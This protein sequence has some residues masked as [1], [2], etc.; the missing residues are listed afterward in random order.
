MSN[1]RA[2]LV[3]LHGI[4]GNAAGF[5]PVV[6]ALEALGWPAV[7]WSQPG[8]DGTPL[9]EPYCLDAC[10]QALGAWL[11]TRGPGRIVL[12]GHSMGGMLAQA[13]SAQGGA[14]ASGVELAGLVLAHTSPAF[15]KPGGDFQQRFIASRTRPLDEGKTM[16]EIAATLVPAMMAPTASAAAQ[17]AGVAMM[18]AV[19]P[20]TYRLAIAAIS[21]FDRR[22]HLGAIVVP[23]LCLAAGQDETA[24]PIVLER[25]AQRIPGADYECLPDLG[26]LAPIEDPQR[27]AG[28]L[29]AWCE[30]RIASDRF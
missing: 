4:G 28:A 24:A 26:H 22:A 12:V 16:R 9:V 15:G 11:A 3:L 21:A 30:R 10:A 8:Y 17:E 7:A 18:A 14:A 5:A 20:P 23:T 13:F 1:G 25:M 29:A 2:T 19:P 27:W 6:R